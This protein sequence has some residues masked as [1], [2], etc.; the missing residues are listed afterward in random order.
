MWG[1]LSSPWKACFEEAWDA[2]CHGSIPIGAVVV[3]HNANIISRGRNRINESSAPFRQTYSNRLAHAE[4]NALLQLDMA[5]SDKLKDFTLYTTTEPCVLCF[6]AVTM[7][8]IRKV[9]Y[10]ATDPVAGGA[11][12]IFANNSF[13]Q[14]R[15]IDFECEEK[16]IGEIQRVLRTD[17]VI[18]TLGY[19]NASRFLNEYRKEYPEA[20][21]LGIQWYEEDI[22]QEAL[23]ERV[24]IDVIID[25]ISDEIK[26]Y[27]A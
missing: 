10:A 20:I 27:H 17:H 24:P 13:I 21:Q 4:I 7:S 14:S 26:S 5:E 1:K 8:G 23:K 3:D 25:K 11:N 2:Y 6:G 18:R 22:L 16:H 19:E 12:L 15:N 9:R